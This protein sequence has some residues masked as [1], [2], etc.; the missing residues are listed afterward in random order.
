MTAKPD[1]FIVDDDRAMRDSL[2]LLLQT[3]GYSVA[4]FDGAE[5]FLGACT[6]DCEGCLI[7]DISMP[8]MGGLTLQKTLREHNI[9]LATVFLTGY[10]TIPDA[11]RAMRD[12][13]ADFLTKPVNGQVLL[14]CVSDALTRCRAKSGHSSSAR[15]VAERLSHLTPRERE[16][17]TLVAK[18]R[19]SK[20]IGQTLGISY[21]TVEVH[22]RHLMTKLGTTSN[23]E[24]ARLVFAFQEAW[25]PP[26]PE[27]PPPEARA[28]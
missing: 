26:A 24:V 8:G 14:N 13:A 9:N 19:S 6:P 12:G 18:G 16:I 15:A 3:A 5:A 7:L 17:V 1:I 27:A 20:E 21:R 22:R 11:V 28:Q 2:A 25:A 10:G 4:V 23:L